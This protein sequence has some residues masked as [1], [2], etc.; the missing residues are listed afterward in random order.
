M[1][2]MFKGADNVILERLGS[3]S[4]QRQHYDTTLVHLERFA[5]EGLRTLCLGVSVIKE[6]LE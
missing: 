5:T 6:R 1:F 4:Q 2:L 3:R